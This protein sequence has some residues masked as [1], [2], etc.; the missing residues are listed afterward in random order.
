MLSPTQLITDVMVL[1]FDTITTDAYRTLQH[2]YDACASVEF[3]NE[4]SDI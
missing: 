3:A 2:A 4:E 1:N